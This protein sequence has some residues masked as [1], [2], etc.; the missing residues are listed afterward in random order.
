MS[1]G[2]IGLIP[3]FT[4]SIKKK[5]PTLHHLNSHRVVNVNYDRFSSGLRT[6]R[7]AEESSL[8][9]SANGAS[10]DKTDRGEGYARWVSNPTDL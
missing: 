3:E 7:L 4:S 10:N 8:S 6:D 9:S 1:S 5:E 2:P